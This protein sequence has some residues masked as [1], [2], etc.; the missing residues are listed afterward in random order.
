MFNQPT[1]PGFSDAISSQESADGNTPLSLPDGPTTPPFGR[2]AVHA[3]HSAMPAR[4]KRKPTSDTF[5]QSYFAL[6]PSAD[7]QS[8]LANRLRAALDVNGSPE[9]VLTWKTWAMKSGPRICALRASER[10]TDDNSF[11]GWPTPLV[12]DTNGRSQ[13]Q[14]AIHG[15]KHGC[16]CLVLA[17]QSLKSWATPRARDSK[18]NGVSIARAA[19][20]VADSLDLQCKLVSQV[21]MAPRS[22]LDARMARDVFRLNPNHS[23]WLMGFP[24]YWAVFSLNLQTKS[25]ME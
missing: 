18:K 1:L 11:T 12:H 24:W 10:P 4:A 19:K 16:S 8:C 25:P 6:S 15:T 9:F 14:K 2:E 21:G 20:G 3:S 17:A 13:Q 5:G 23:L 22:P 7:L